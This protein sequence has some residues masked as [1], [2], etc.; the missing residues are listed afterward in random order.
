MKASRHAVRSLIVLNITALISCRNQEA[1]KRDSIPP[2]AAEKIEHK[3]AESGGTRVDNYYWM[4]LT[5]EQKNAEQKDEQTQKV[6]NYLNAEND[7]LKS[8][9]A[10]TDS[11]AAKIYREIIGRIKQ[12]DESVPYKK[13]GYWYYQKYEQGKEYP[14]YCRK[15]GSMDAA[16][17][18]ILNQNELAAGHDYYSISDLSVSDD[19]RLLA[20]G[21]DSV[22]RRRYTIYVKDLVTGK[23]VGNPIANTEG[24]AT[25]AN[26]NKTFFYTRKDSVTL[27]SRWI[28]RHKLNT[29]ASQDKAVFEEKDETF[30]T[31]IY[32]TKSNKFLV[33]WSGS[34]LTSDYHVLDAGKPDGI[35]AAFSARE[36]GLEYSIDHYKDKFYIVT[37]LDAQ[38][39]RLM[40]TP[41]R[42]TAKPTGKKR[43]LTGRIPCSRELRFSKTTLC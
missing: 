15:K 5:D 17:E 30:Y 37:N 8:K 36:R 43:L 35:F 32:K 20:Y 21:E 7:Y 3:F 41:D 13:N 11:L 40:E 25:W 10:H 31:G 14:I 6:L 23:L 18:V 16:E 1:E 9:L 2:P 39:F 33:I 24:E 38:N 27:R 12:T 34:T 29:E 42:S 22:S 4:K 28:M 26:D 19:N